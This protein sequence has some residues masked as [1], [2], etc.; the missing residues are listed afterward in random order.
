MQCC[1]GEELLAEQSPF[2]VHSTNESSV[3]FCWREGLPGMQTHTKDCEGCD[4]ASILITVQDVDNI[5]FTFWMSPPV[6]HAHMSLK[7]SGPPPNMTGIE[8]LM[9]LPYVQ[10]KMTDDCAKFQFCPPSGPDTGAR[11]VP[12]RPSGCAYTAAMQA[13]TRLS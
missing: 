7:R 10:C 3:K 4:C 6:I 11:A 9:I 12:H 5:E 8:D 1:F 2:S 13:Q